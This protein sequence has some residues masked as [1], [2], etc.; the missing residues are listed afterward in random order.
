MRLIVFNVFKTVWNDG[1]ECTLT[2]FAEGGEVIE[3][4]EQAT[5]WERPQLAESL[6]QQDLH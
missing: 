2:K 4:E 3:L 6:G 1:T 5:I